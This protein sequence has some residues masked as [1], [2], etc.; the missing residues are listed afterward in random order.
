MTDQE[1]LSRHEDVHEGLE[2]LLS[3]QGLYQAIKAGEDALA[4]TRYQLGKL[5]QSPYT[6]PE[7]KVIEIKGSEASPLRLQKFNEGQWVE[8]APDSSDYIA[9]TRPLGYGSGFRANKISRFGQNIWAHNS[10]LQIRVPLELGGGAFI[11]EVD[12]PKVEMPSAT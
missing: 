12:V 2:R 8:L 6:P 5:D 10:A 1:R 7:G 4:A 11:G 9:A 3:I